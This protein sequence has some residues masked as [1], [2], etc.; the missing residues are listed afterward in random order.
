MNALIEGDDDLTQ[1]MVRALK[2]CLRAPVRS[3]RRGPLTESPATLLV[4]DVGALSV[5]A[6]N[7]L[8]EWLSVGAAPRRVIATS[9]RPVFPM[10]ERGQFRADLYYHLNIILLKLR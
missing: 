2:P 10:V 1:A 9:S 7:A 3:W 4:A 6:Q 5:E 8:L